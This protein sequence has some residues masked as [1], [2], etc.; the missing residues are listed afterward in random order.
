MKAIAE[1]KM[2]KVAGF[3]KWEVESWA[4]TL[5]EAEEIKADPKKMKAVMP[6]LKSK[7]KA[8]K[9]IKSLDDLRDRA[10][11]MDEEVDED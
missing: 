2:E 8:L 1:P 7:I 3:D 9:G 10:K 11:E 5:Q 4:R 6:L